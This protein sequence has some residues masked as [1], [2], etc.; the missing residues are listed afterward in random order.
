VRHLYI[1][2]QIVLCD[3]A[4]TSYLPSEILW[5]HRFERLVK[6]RREDGM[7]QVDY[8]RF[9]QT[10]PVSEGVVSRDSAKQQAAGRNDNIDDETTSTDNDDRHDEGKHTF[11][12]RLTG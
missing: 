4:R 3:Q 8:A 6:Y 1:Y 11:Q 2:E 12:H 7:Y 10:V 5:G 9:H